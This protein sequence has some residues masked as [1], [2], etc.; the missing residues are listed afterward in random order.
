METHLQMIFW[1]LHMKSGCV[2]CKLSV[3]FVSV[4]VC[5]CNTYGSP[6][7]CAIEICIRWY[8]L[9]ELAGG[10][11]N[12]EGVVIFLS[13]GGGVIVFNHILWMGLYIHVYTDYAVILFNI[14]WQYSSVQINKLKGEGMDRIEEGRG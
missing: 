5:V 1:T 8:N 3:F 12:S 13:F 7:W 6:P 14:A 10:S 2:W 11:Y 4:C 9:K